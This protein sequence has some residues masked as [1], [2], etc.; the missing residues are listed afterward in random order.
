MFIVSSSF[1]GNFKIGDNINYNLKVLK[2][3]YHSR[4][5]LPEDGRVY[6][7]KPITV[8]LVSICEAL[9]YDFIFR[10][11]SFTREGI[12]GLDD[13]QLELLRNQKSYSM[14]DKIKL[15]QNLN[16]LK[17]NDT[18]VYQYLG[19]LVKLRNR[20]HIQNEFQ[21]LELDEV[22]AFTVSRRVEA[23]KM[24]E[25]FMRKLGSLYPRPQHIVMSQ[26]VEDFELPWNA[27]F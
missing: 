18:K 9:M 12:D 13:E 3:L 22:N 5:F 17:T 2:A 21:N 20:I 19:Y 14:E 1:I 15:I 26:F 8:I 25:L 6:L 7:E 10:S 23:E 27:H 24:L 16:L 4:N 11:K